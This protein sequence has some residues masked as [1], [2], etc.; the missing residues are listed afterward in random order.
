[1]ELHHHHR[2]VFAALHATEPKTLR[3]IAKDVTPQ[4]G[5]NAHTHS[6]AVRTWLNWLEQAGY[7]KRISKGEK[8]TLWLRSRT[9]LPAVFHEDIPNEEWLRSKLLQVQEAGRNA[10]GVPAVMGSITGHFDRTLD[11]PV[12][13]LA[14]VPGERGEQQH[15]RH[16]ALQYLQKHWN[17]IRTE[18][19][20]V[21]IDPYGKA[22]MNEGNH[23]IMVALERGET[24]YPVQIRYFSGGQ[25]HTE[26]WAPSRL[27]R[28]DSEINGLLD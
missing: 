24:S 5:H 28:L 26:A 12:S 18:A 27:I 25:R 19:V 10:W 13:L 15:I 11:L 1:M 20:Y 23:R 8:P 7:A 22:W 9:V 3:A 2:K 17:D 21:E 6:G 16:D 4:F 14:S